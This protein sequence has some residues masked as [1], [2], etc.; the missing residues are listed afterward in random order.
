MKQP[1]APT[2]KVSTLKRKRNLGLL[3]YELERR[4]REQQL[5]KV[6]K[7][8]AFVEA[9]LRNEQQIIRRK[10]CEKDE[11][12]NRQMCTIRNMKRKY[13]DTEADDGCS[14]AGEVAQFCPKCRKS[15]YIQ[16]QAIAWTQTL[17]LDDFAAEEQSSLQSIEYMSSSEEAESINSF[18]GARH[19]RKYTS[20]RSFKD[21]QVNKRD[22]SSSERSFILESMDKS[23][24]KENQESNC[25]S[26]TGS[27]YSS[28]MN[29]M[30]GIKSSMRS[31]RSNGPSSLRTD[32]GEYTKSIS[33]GRISSSF[34]SRP[35]DTVIYNNST[36][37]DRPS[38]EDCDISQKYTKGIEVKT[39]I[40]P[41]DDWYVSA[42]D[43]EEATENGGYKQ[44]G[45]NG[46]NPVLECMNQILLQEPMEEKEKTTP[47]TPTKSPST[48]RSKR[49]H[50]S[51]SNTMVQV[52]RAQ[53][54]ILEQDEIQMIGYDI[55]F[56]N[57]YEPVGSSNHYVDINSKQGSED[58]EERK[59]RKPPALPPK[60]ANLLRLPNVQRPRILRSK[61]SPSLDGSSEPDYCSISDVK[62]TKTV[63][64]IAEIHKSAD[65]DYSTV[66]DER[67]DSSNGDFE[68]SFEDV[69]K[70]PMV[71]E[72]L[73][74][75]KKDIQRYIG[76]DNYITKSPYK[77]QAIRSSLSNRQKIA[78]I[79]AEITKQTAPPSSTKSAT[80]TYDSPVPVVSPILSEADEHH[81]S[82]F[83]WYH[84]DKQSIIIVE[85]EEE[86]IERPSDPITQDPV[87]YS[88]DEA[89]DYSGTAVKPPSIF[90]NLVALA[91]TPAKGLKGDK[92]YQFFLE[93]SGLSSKAILP[94]KKRVYYS[95]P[96]V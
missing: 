28:F 57:E 46:G 59:V 58:S 93:D 74:P 45:Q 5:T 17:P 49:V 24:D 47:H 64:I 6:L 65:D 90:K 89:E 87:F 34:S 84:A 80:P 96:F 39:K 9:K 12:I 79:L 50:F 76:R 15:Y 85:R 14:G 36:P 72:I 31:S 60:P 75:K 55:P 48:P 10:L 70:L 94:R 52:P 77:Y 53:Y 29:N 22:P 71:E 18:M 88:G 63:Q 27:V 25:G 40:E 1:D 92:N 54:P 81:K 42:S 33:D 38:E 13:G 41:S 73:T 7:A 78:Q 26:T 3:D 30:H 43:A 19:S 83:D 4:C 8:L 51:I 23:S 37:V 68:E 56:T 82:A 20:K 61:A 32:D 66:R 95:G 69:P 21:F 16:D 44:Y 35:D 91:E 86:K 11:L 2:Q 67:S 62:D